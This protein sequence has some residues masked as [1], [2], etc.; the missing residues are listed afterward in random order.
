MPSLLV[1]DD[2]QS[3]LSCFRM[4][5]RDA[6]TEVRTAGTAAA[7]IESFSKGVP[8]VV[9]LDI[10]LPDRSGLDTFREIQALDP[11]VPVILM[12]GEGTTETAINAI[13]QGAYEY[14]LKPLNILEVRQLV[15]RAIADSLLMRMPALLEETASDSVSDLLIGRCPAM[16][17]VYKEIGRVAGR[18]VTVLILGESGTGKELVARAIYHHSRRANKLFLAINCGAIPETLL[19]SELFGHEKGAFT[20]ADRKRIGRFEQ[21][22]GGTLFLDEIGD[23]TPLTQTKVLR[24]LQEQHFERV[25]GAETIQTDVRVIAATNCDLEQMVHADRFRSD[26]F[27][28]LNVFTIRLPA[29]RERGEDLPVLVEHFHRR[30]CREFQKEVHTIA[31]D[32]LAALC[33]YSWPGNVRELQSVLKQAILQTRGVVLTCEFLPAFIRRKPGVTPAVATLA[34]G[35]GLGDLDHFI[36]ERLAAGSNDL[37][38]QWLA[39]TER[40]LFQRVLNHTKGNL[41]QAARILGIHRITLRTKLI[42]LGMSPAARQVEAAASC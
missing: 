15:M 38:T 37:H 7:G 42:A 3:I 19:E 1:I 12:T 31:P 30:Y 35:A 11:R 6:E 23:M 36:N 41:S 20:S 33:D 32:A 14:L 26:L 16:Q 9:L 22:S 25:G 10:N 5:F 4:A 40:H 2:E 28:R 39:V 34:P 21:C 18:E 29:L 8:D 17:A 13:A 27:Y 24:V